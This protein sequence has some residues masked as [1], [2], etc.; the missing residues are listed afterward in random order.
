MRDAL[1]VLLVAVGLSWTLLTLD[2]LGL[3]V[4][5]AVVTLIAYGVLKP[6]ASGS[7]DGQEPQV[8]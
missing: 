5:F 8:F 4:T 2:K 7:G 3:V 1:G 6:H